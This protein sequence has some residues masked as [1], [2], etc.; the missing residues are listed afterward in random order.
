MAIKK[1]IKE[2][3]KKLN[4]KESDMDKYWNKLIETNWKI[5]SFEEIILNKIDSGEKL[6]KKEL[7][8]LVWEFENQQKVIRLR[9]KHFIKFQDICVKVMLLK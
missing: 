4:L 6:T 8:G 5:K 2:L 1:D 3:L 9:K 7:S